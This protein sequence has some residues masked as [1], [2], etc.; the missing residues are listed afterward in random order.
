MLSPSTDMTLPHISAEAAQPISIAS[1][2][3]VDVEE[4]YQAEIFSGIVDRADRMM[5]PPHV[6][7]NTMELIRLFNDCNVRGTFFILGTVAMKHPGLIRVIQES[8]NEIAS[9]GDDHR[10]ITKMSPPEFREDVRRSKRILEDI[11]G[12]A[13]VGYRAPTFSI[14]EKTEWAYEILL[15][16]GF[17]Y[18]SSVFPIH[19]DRYGWPEF[20]AVPRKMAV[21]GNRWIWEIPLSVERVGFINVPFGGGGYLR[22]FPMFLTKYFFRRSLRVGRPAIVYVH[23]WEIDRQHPRIAMPVLK[24]MR[25]YVGISGMQEKVRNLLRSFRFER[26]DEFMKCACAGINPKPRRKWK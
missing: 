20:G 5:H 19:H 2:L 8:G 9:H 13:V 12:T 11:A 3:T 26:M 6:E 16:E 23:P 24:R 25:H 22:L 14:V 15:D 4:Y 21:R 17:R 7:R 18:S 1:Y 10:M